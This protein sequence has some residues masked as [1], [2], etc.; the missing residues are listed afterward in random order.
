MNPRK[1]NVKCVDFGGYYVGSYPHDESEMDVAID[2][3]DHDPLHD[4]D[5]EE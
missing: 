1:R 4:T 5:S 3:L 2:E